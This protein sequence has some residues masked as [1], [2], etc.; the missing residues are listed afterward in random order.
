[1]TCDGAG[2]TLVKLLTSVKKCGMVLLSRLRRGRRA[3]DSEEEDLKF[4]PLV[5]DEAGECHRRANEQ[6]FFHY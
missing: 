3:G 4:L 6:L 1:M 2:Y 5:K